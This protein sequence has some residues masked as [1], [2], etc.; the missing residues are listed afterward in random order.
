MATTRARKSRPKPSARKSSKTHTRQVAITDWSKFVRI[1]ESWSG[2]RNWAFRG[3]ARADWPLCSSLS[4]HI[5]LTGVCEEA[6]PVQEGRIRRIFQRKSHL[7]L[8]D[9]PIDDELEW[10]ALMQHH[11][12]PTRLLD[13]TWSP[14]VAAFFALEHLINRRFDEAE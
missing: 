10:L 6:W 11:G 1:I 4:R 5:D 2:F 7:F 8:D 14:F 12:A 13:F 9:A 3:Q